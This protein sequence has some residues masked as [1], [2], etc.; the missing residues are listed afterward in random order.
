MDLKENRAIVLGV[1]INSQYSNKEIAENSLKELIEL[2]ETTGLEVVG[3]SIQFR[4][5][6][7]PTYAAGSGKLL[8]IAKTA[9]NLEAD[10]IVL[11][12]NLSG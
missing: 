2:S 12:L 3:E 10:T 6:F 9:K 4:K 5:K 1:Y 11:D 7:N 8:E